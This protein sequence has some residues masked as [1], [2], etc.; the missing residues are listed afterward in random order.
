MRNVMLFEEYVAI[1]ELVSAEQLL[2]V[3]DYAKRLFRVLKMDFDVTGT[4]LAD[5]INDARNGKEITANE[6]IGL[7]KRTVMQKG[8]MIQT[9]DADAEGVI[10]DAAT[11]LN[12]PFVIQ[13]NGKGLNFIP[14]S[15]MRKKGFFSAG[16]P[17]YV[18]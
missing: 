11:D 10:K 16:V 8:P 7:L 9:L 14:K 17:V 4:H 5:R 3:I 12:M 2:G 18:H 1:N 13:W 15:I 6:L